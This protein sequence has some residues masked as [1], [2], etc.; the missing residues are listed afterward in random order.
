MHP[1][2][3]TPGV[4]AIRSSRP[5]VPTRRTIT[6]PSAPETSAETGT[7]STSPSV[8]AACTV[9]RTSWPANSAGNSGYRPR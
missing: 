6:R 5:A 7:T 1:S 9:N 2:P 4:T 3:E 8:A